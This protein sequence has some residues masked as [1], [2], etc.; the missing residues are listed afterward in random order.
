[1]T[2]GKIPMS[3]VQLK[4]ILEKEGDLN[5][6]GSTFSPQYLS[7]F[8]TKFNKTPVILSTEQC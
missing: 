5:Y 3:C 4:P 8:E 1:M 7:L 2:D 6:K